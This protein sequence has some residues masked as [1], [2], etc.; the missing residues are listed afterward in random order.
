MNEKDFEFDLDFDFEKE[1]GFD[2][3]EDTAAQQSGD[4][5]DLKALLTGMIGGKMAAGE[6][7]SPTVVVAQP[8]PPA[9][10]P[11]LEV[12]ELPGEE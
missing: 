12:F 11:P 2:T 6:N 1:Y 10:T 9:V 4:D 3:P 8:A 5:I 7:S